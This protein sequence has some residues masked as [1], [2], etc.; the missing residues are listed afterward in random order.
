MNE[1][2]MKELNK[3]IASCVNKEKNEAGH[4]KE[5]KEK[6]INKKLNKI[7]KQQEG[8]GGINASSARAMPAYLKRILCPT[9]LVVKKKQHCTKELKC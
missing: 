3:I 4:I 2:I 8:D 6:S 1:I 5:S 9:I 7:A